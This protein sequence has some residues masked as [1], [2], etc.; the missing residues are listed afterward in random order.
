MPQYHNT[1]FIV[2]ATA[3]KKLLT[4][5][6]LAG[7][8]LLMIQLFQPTSVSAVKVGVQIPE[9]GKDTELLLR[10]FSKLQPAF[11]EVQESHEIVDDEINSDT[12]D[13][14]TVQKI[15]ELVTRYVEINPC[16]RYY[17]HEYMDFRE[18]E[19]SGN[20]RNS[21]TNALI[22]IDIQFLIEPDQKTQVLN[23]NI[24]DRNLNMLRRKERLDKKDVHMVVD[25]SFFNDLDKFN[26]EYIDVCFENIKVDK[27]W[28]SRPRIIDAYMTLEFGMSQ[29][30]NNYKKS[31]E[32][33]SEQGKKLEEISRELTMISHQLHDNVVNSES[34]LRNTN[35]DTNGKVVIMSFCFVC[36]LT[37]S[38]LAQ[39]I[40][41]I[42]YLKKRGFI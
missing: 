12:E 27:S 33:L 29:I 11:K 32:G 10:E 26:S 37:L 18:F 17:L 13:D 4:T 31:S 25:Y 3:I 2:S 8:F 28:S 36:F 21:L 20:A 39:L 5:C 38:C 1:E 15:R 35:E 14:K 42:S 19:F 24:L 9:S 41:L 34:K 40:W 16:F 23:L 22:A 7:Y 30:V 6:L